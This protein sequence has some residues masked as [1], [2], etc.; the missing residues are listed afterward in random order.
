[1][2]LPPE[3]PVVVA[4]SAPFDTPAPVNA[5]QVAR[6]LAARG[7]A[8]LF[9]ESTG[10]RAPRAGSVWDRRR[11]VA[12][13]AAFARGVREAAPRLHVLAPLALPGA[14]PAWLRRLSLRALGAQA[15]RAARRLE[16]REPVLWAFLP[17][18]LGLV[19]A[20]RP[21]LV[22]Y[23]CVDHYAANPGVA[24][25]WIE[26]LEAAM[27]QRADVV[28]ATSP[29]LAE[30][31]SAARADVRL[32]PNGADVALFGRAVREALPEPALLHERPR[33]RLVYVG[34]LAAYR[35][36]TGWLLAL[37]QARPGATLVLVGAHGL[38]DV[39]ADE[40]ERARLLALPNVVAAGA[41][42]Q[43][44]LPALL[45]HCDAALI[46]FRDNEHTRGSLPLKLWEYLAAG[47]P[48]VARDLPNFAEV[49]AQGLV[50]VA[51]DA[52]GFVQACDAALAEPP[53][54]RLQ[55]ARSAEA[56]DWPARMEALCAAVGAAL[57]GA[58]PARA[59]AR[60]V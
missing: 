19:P 34:N 39:G 38:G 23:H 54:H 46:P 15:A 36:E 7:H 42:P 35:V 25:A 45:R 10:L 26:A 1:V 2:T 21:R 52:A 28:F 31:L 59:G 14:G 12:R 55:R 47:L 41:L 56:H 4:A 18:A 16:L 22:V 57:A 44:G 9:V 24:R 20:L 11:G 40:P 13:L 32:V 30:R 3:V 50:R 43:A 33:P 5:H 60:R 17:T 48:V 51:R 53:E 37:A 29:V 8:V 58:A 49:A 27:L 6:R